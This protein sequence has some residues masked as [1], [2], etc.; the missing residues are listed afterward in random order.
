MKASFEKKDNNQVVL[1]VEAGEEKV[2]VALDQAFKKV[3]KKVNVPGFRKGKIPRPLFEKRFGVESLYQDALDI[4]LPQ[5]YEEAIKETGIE[6]VDRPEVDVEQMEKGKALIFKATITVKP[7]VVLG[8]YKNLEIEE[9]DF[10]VKE[11]AIDEELSKMQKQQGTLEPIEAGTVANGDNV[12][13]DFEGFVDGVAFEGGN[14][15]NFALEIGSNSFIPGFEEQLIGV[16]LGEERDIDV[17]FPEDYRATDLA[18]APA[19]FRVKLH[20]IKRQNLPE[21]DDE[22]AQEVSE[23]DTLADLK[24]DIEHKL[25]ER[26]GKEQQDYIRNQVVELAA[27]NADIDVPAVMIDHEVEHMYSHFVQN[28]TYQGLNIELYTQLTGQ[29]ETDIKAQMKEDA[30]KKVRA[31]LVIEA[32]SEFEQVEVTDEDVETE[33]IETAAEMKREVEEVRDIIQKQGS[34][35]SLRDSIKRKKTI[36][37]LVLNRKNTA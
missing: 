5:A 21:L 22:F 28:L 16:E 23:C 25:V 4:L 24:A 3:V 7:E 31:D 12:V 2:T 32:I 19:T 36:D 1:T 14:G 26:L 27:N 29:S 13:I 6:P 10:S 8:A 34:I 33:I 20:E 9:K 35:D 18:G 37:L 17:T 30:T 11:E 15:E